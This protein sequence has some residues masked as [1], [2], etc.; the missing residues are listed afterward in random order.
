MSYMSHVNELIPRM[1]YYLGAF[2]V[3]LRMTAAIVHHRVWA[4]RLLNPH[5]C[6]LTFCTL[7]L[8]PECDPWCPAV[9]QDLQ[10][11]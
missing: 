9:C 7:L 11:I 4:S 3:L 1:W 10:H 6:S 5:H 2:M 8:C